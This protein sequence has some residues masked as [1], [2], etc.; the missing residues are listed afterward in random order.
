MLKKVKR[1]YK[2]LKE[3]AI[4]LHNKLKKVKRGCKMLKKVKRS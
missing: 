1:S 4:G 2:R 3:A